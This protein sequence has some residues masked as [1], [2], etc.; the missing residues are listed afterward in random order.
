MMDVEMLSDAVDSKWVDVFAT[1]YG[2]V[3]DALQE[4]HT[5]RGWIGALAKAIAGRQEGVKAKDDKPYLAV[6]RSIERYEAGQFKSLKSY[7]GKMAEVGR[8]LPPI[9]RALP[10]NKIT[11]TVK[12]D[13]REGKGTRERSFTTTFTGPD[14]YGFANEPTY[15]TFFKKQG[16]PDWVI[17][18]FE[19]GDYE[20]VVSSVA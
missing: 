11:L 6:R 5:G 4:K 7:G 20:L 15:R 1:S 3:K 19:A 13:Q 8:T 14:A 10:G 18:K 16:Y 17:D 12:G 2:D 9:G